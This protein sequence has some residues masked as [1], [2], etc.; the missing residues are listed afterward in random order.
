MNWTDLA[1]GR[2]KWWTGANMEMDEL[3]PLNAANF[4]TL[5]GIV[6]F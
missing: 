5:R 4:L 3:F 6:S 2:R 1:E